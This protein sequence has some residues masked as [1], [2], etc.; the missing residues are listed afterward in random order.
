LN[1]DGFF[2]WVEWERLFQMIWMGTIF[3]LSQ[4]RFVVANRLVYIYSWMNGFT[5]V[6]EV[7][8]TRMSGVYAGEWSEVYT[9]E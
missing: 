3:Y 1:E 6:S 5:R 2:S 4:L 8:F 9:A 7:G